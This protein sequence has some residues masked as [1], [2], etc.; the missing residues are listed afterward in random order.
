M[1]DIEMAREAIESTYIGECDIVE[2]VTIKN[3]ITKRNEHK[4]EKVLEK[5]KCRISFKNISNSFRLIYG[6]LETIISNVSFTF[7]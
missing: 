1:T 2:Y 6:G 5:Q 7:S 3:D 4:E